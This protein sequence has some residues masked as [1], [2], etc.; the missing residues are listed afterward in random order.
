MLLIGPPGS[1]KTHFVLEAL[2]TAIREG[3]AAQSK[4]IVPTTSMA[5]HL[6]HTLARRGL[7]VPGDLVQTIA[8]VVR[9]VTPELGV[10]SAAMESRLLDA[11][12]D[13]EA[14]KA[15]AGLENSRGLRRRIAELMREF[16]AAGTD[17]VQLEGLGK[18]KHQRAFLAVFRAYEESLGEAGLV[19]RNQ[20][21]AQAAAE[22]RSSGLGPVKRIYLDGFFRFTKQ[23]QVFVEALAE[24]SESIVVTMPDGLA[25]YPFKD[26]GHRLLSAAYR[27]QP[28]PI[29]VEASSPREEVMEIARRILDSERPFRHCG[30]VLRSPSRYARL[31]EEI[32][33]ALNIPFRMRSDEKLAAHG[34][35]RYLRRWLT[36]ICDAFPA[37]TTLELICSPL[38]PAGGSKDAYDFAVR[39][40]LP[41]D[42]PT[43]LAAEAAEYQ[44]I[45]EFL[46]DLP[47]TANWPRERKTAREWAEVIRDFCA[48]LLEPQT[49]VLDAKIE[50]RTRV[51]AERQFNAALDSAADLTLGSDEERISLIEFVTR[52]DD[53]LE[54][55]PLTGSDDRREVVHV[56]SVYEARQWA[57]PVVFVC[58][59]VGGWFP[60]Q[61]W[62][63]LFFSDSDRERLSGRGIQLRSSLDRASEEQ[64]LYRMATTRATE[65]LVLTYPRSD[66]S[67]SPKLRS[68]FVGQAEPVVAA[69]MV[70]A[71]IG[72]GKPAV[73][74]ELDGFALE[75]I[76]QRHTRFSPSGLD[77]YLQCPYQFFAARTLDLSGRPDI[78]E[79]RFGALTAGTIV[80]EVL[81]RWTRDG[82]SIAEILDH[83]F[84]RELAKAHLRLNFRSALIRGNM[85]ADLERFAAEL[86]KPPVDGV[87]EANV[88]YELDELEPAATIAGRVDRYEFDEAGNCF[89]TD[90][91]YSGPSRVE[92]LRVGHER[93]EHLQLPLYMLGLQKE[94]G[95]LPGGM[96]LCGIRGETRY[97]GWSAVEPNASSTLKVVARDYLQLLVTNARST[98]VEAIR[99]VREGNIAADPRDAVVCDRYCEFKSVCRIGWSAAE[100]SDA[101]SA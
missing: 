52:L 28:T 60:P 9:A 94:H 56:L 53:V 76:S 31:I 81:N 39:E 33:G 89:L 80:H 71:S 17:N 72:V 66:E 78:A 24:Q 57:L 58:G 40:K 84:N 3:R 82:G 99:E 55:T 34:V 100:Q 36:T 44:S 22:I 45:A 101:A 63:D 6:L 73:V 42:G 79:F 96:A 41:G 10:V 43:L 92:S 19:H 74:A 98:A 59:L 2:E 67:G 23:E 7:L 4:L 5:Q 88:G 49:F 15:F 48:K 83:V 97:E 25:P 54:S 18:N 46:D 77:S 13:R 16:W 30:I 62:Q 86:G 32:F 65:T 93:G 27:P 50:Q 90:Y 8:D 87:S 95:F 11:A 91:K 51:S 69:P 70:V 37:E 75:R 12:I 47:P 21:I 20:C 1:G 61:S 26:L 29:V 64:F 35:V 68:F 14:P 85:R 38:S